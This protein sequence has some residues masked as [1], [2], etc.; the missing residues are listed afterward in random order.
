MERIIE[1]VEKI[2]DNAWADWT[3]EEKHQLLKIYYII[4]K[5]ENY[6]FDLIYGYHGCDSWEDIFR[7]YDHHHLK[8]KASGVK[9]AIKEIKDQIEELKGKKE[10]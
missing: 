1:K 2:K 10:K 5:K 4:S 7:D 3:L 8:D 6:I 9:I